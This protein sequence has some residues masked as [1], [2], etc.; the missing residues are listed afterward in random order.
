AAGVT[1]YQALTGHYPYGEIEA[2]QR[3]HF[4]QPTAASRYRPDLPVWVDQQLLH[5]ICADPDERFE[6]AEQWLLE[7]E[8]GERQS[9]AIRPRPLLEREPLAVWRTVALIALALNVVLFIA[10]L[11]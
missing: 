6:T 2:F 3:P 5:A 8:H 4:K 7:I 1:L 11:R 10:V 9:L